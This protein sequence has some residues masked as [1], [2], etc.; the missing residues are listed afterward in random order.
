MNIAIAERPDRIT[1][2]QAMARSQVLTTATSASADF[3]VGSVNINLLPTT[4]QN[5]SNASAVTGL[6]NK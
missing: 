2:A 1:S 5:C 6:L 4:E 3:Y